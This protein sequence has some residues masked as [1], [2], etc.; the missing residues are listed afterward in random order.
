MAKFCFLVVG[1]GRG[2]TSLLAALLNQHP[3]I[4]CAMEAFAWDYLVEGK[5]NFW[6][7]Q[8]AQARFQRFFKKCNTEAK[9]KPKALYANK[10]TTEQILRALESSNEKLGSILMYL[11]IDLKII[12][13]VR[14][15]RTQVPS[16]MN[17]AK[18]TLEES[19]LL[20]N[21]AGDIQELLQKEKNNNLLT[22][23]YEDLVCAPRDTMIQIS[24]FLK[25]PFHSS[26]IELEKENNLP[27]I[28]Q[29][30]STIEAQKTINN[31]D[32]EWLSNVSFHMRRFGYL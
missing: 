23:K 15:A 3:Q 6:Q 10:I 24:E 30:K 12:F 21:K 28:Y 29:E 5:R 20:W 7:Q 18:K 13:C 1:G 17:R 19:C 16:K 25:I 4:T 8:G 32:P 2:G 31:T 9:K 14:D 22:I 26:L 11:P 27:A